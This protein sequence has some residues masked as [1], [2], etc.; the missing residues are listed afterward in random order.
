[1]KDVTRPTGYFPWCKICHCAKQKE[2]R[3]KKIEVIETGAGKACAV[4]LVIMP[5][6]HSNRMYC[7]NLCK[8]RASR[9]AL[10]GLV[11]EEFRKLTA[12]GRCPICQ[13]A[14]KKWAV[15]H[16]HQTGETY[17]P[18]CTGCNVGIVAGSHHSIEKVKRLLA[19]L[20]NPPTRALSEERK[21]VGQLGSSQ[22][23]RMWLWKSSQG[24]VL[25]APEELAA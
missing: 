19:F 15:D 6:A 9:W 4:C 3:R 20:E 18:I 5:N 7:S 24:E 12:S 1:M 2:Y 16:N 25:P 17:G 14:V 8:R 21:Y 10:Y 22:L 13:C 11:P 23:H